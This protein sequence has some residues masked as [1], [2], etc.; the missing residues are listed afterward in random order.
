MSD[1]VKTEF[2]LGRYWGNKIFTVENVDFEMAPAIA[3]QQGYATS[4]RK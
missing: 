3:D 2:F 1:V 4:S